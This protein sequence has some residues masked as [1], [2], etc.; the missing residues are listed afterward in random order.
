MQKYIKILESYTAGI[1]NPFFVRG[2]I[3]K[4]REI[5]PRQDKESGFSLEE[6][7]AIPV[8]LHTFAL[9]KMK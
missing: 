2:K 8:I 1:K 4:N 5:L 6:T 9:K 7:Y 3:D